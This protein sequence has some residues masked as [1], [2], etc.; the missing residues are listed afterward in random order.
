[1]LI[2]M[3]YQTHAHRVYELDIQLCSVVFLGSRQDKLSVVR[4]SVIS[5]DDTLNVLSV[6]YISAWLVA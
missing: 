4:I 1:M 3:L 5:E 6:I 2:W